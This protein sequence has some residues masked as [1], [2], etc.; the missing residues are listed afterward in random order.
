[1]LASVVTLFMQGF[2]ACSVRKF[3][4]GALR[5]R[6]E[7]GRIY[8]LNGCSNQFTP[9]V[10]LKFALLRNLRATQNHTGAEIGPKYI[11]RLFQ[12]HMGTQ[13][14]TMASPCLPAKS[15]IFYRW[16]R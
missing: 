1:M 8:P 6:A 5:S 11:F 10:A 9:L 7:Y 3:Y 15:S 4:I 2:D 14:A 12:T 13:A 16:H